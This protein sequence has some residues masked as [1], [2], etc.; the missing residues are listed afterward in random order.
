MSLAGAIEHDGVLVSASTG[1]VVSEQT[2]LG[3][4]VRLV[5]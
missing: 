4:E 3:V 1:R 5:E 2:A